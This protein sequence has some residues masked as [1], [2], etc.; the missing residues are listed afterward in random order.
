MRIARGKLSQSG[1]HDHP[2]S[3][4]VGHAIR[5]HPDLFLAATLILT[6]VE[7]VGFCPLTAES[8]SGYH[9]WWTEGTQGN[10]SPC[11]ED[12]GVQCCPLSKAG[13]PA[14]VWCISAPRLQAQGRPGPL[15]CPHH[16]STCP[17]VRSLEPCPRT[18]GKHQMLNRS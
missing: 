6:A 10:Q 8:L 3:Q 4:I 18:T 12:S 2:A 7:N 14:A 5:S 9:P 1:L 17:S 13:L 11:P 15:A 16:C